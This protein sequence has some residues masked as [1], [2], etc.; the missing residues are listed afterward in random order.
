MNA[1]DRIAVL[2]SIAAEVRNGEMPPKPYTL[3]H[4]T[5]R[6]SESDKQQIVVWTR[7]ERKRIKSEQSAKKEIGT[8]EAGK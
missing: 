5:N 8:R 2:A 3:L 6:L 4:R 1:E 7:A